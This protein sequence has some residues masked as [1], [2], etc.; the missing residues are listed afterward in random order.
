ML[1][2]EKNPL[3]EVRSATLENI[4]RRSIYTKTLKS[5]LC[6]LLAVNR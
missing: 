1:V 4:P 3:I 2:M 6:G 5:I